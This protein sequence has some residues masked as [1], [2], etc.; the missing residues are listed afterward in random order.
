[1][2][3]DGQN[4]IPNVIL[5]MVDIMGTRHNRGKKPT[6]EPSVL[7]IMIATRKIRNSWDD[8]TRLIRSG[9]FSHAVD[10]IHQWTAPVIHVMELEQIWGHS[11]SNLESP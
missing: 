3:D 11:F 7:D 10:K 6:Y 2:K 5:G 4:V 9:V 8:R 1:M